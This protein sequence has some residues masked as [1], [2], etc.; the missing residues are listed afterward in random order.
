MIIDLP[1]PL[2]LMNTANPD[3]NSRPSSV[4][5]N[6]SFCAAPWVHLCGSVDGLFT[7]CCIDST[8]YDDF[9]SYFETE[10]PS[11]TLSDEVLGCMPGSP[12][13]VDNPDRVETLR[14]AFNSSAM[15]APRL[16]MVEGK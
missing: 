15:Q 8:M 9:G 4:L 13:A 10:K 5:E 2:F 12:F 16:A 6:A 14:G 7:R 3:V 11:I 1:L